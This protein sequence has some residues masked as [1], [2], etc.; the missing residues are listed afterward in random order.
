[1][2][3]EILKAFENLKPGWYDGD[4]GSIPD[5]QVLQQLEIDFNREV[6]NFEIV[7]IAYPVPEGGVQIEWYCKSWELS[8]EINYNLNKI[9]YHYYNFET[10]LM[11]YMG[12]NDSKHCNQ[13]KT[14]NFIIDLINRKLVWH[15]VL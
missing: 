7:P 10:D 4:L 11:I 14:L 1:M 12:Y 9:M 13:F 8:V 15:Y 3:I 6:V 2:G 5:L